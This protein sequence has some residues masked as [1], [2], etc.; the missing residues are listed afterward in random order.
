[1]ADSVE[2][3]IDAVRRADLDPA[4]VDVADA[5][6]FVQQTAWPSHVALSPEPSTDPAADAVP[7]DRVSPSPTSAPGDDA[8]GSPST[9][10][11]TAAPAVGSEHVAVVDEVEIRRPAP[12]RQP[13]SVPFRAPAAPALPA[14]LRMAR[15]L[16]P[17]KRRVVAGSDGDLDADATAHLAAQTDVL[18]PVFASRMERWLDI[19]VVIDDAPSMA[20]SAQTVQELV[21]I[22]SELG[23]FRDIR[24][25]RLN[26]DDHTA[27]LRLRA[28][29]TSAAAVHDPRELV[30]PTGRRAVV[31]V[32]DCLGKAWSDGRMAAALE[33]WADAGPVAVV[34][35]L[36]QRLWDDCGP[37]IH[38]V[39]LRAKTPG[40]A[41]SDLMVEINDDDL[42]ELD[43]ASIARKRLGTVVP[44]IELGE[45]WL[46]A[47]AAVVAGGAERSFRGKALFL[48]LM[49]LDTS[50]RPGTEVPG[51]APA[52]PVQVVERF[53]ATA[54]TDALSLAALLA[55]AAPLTLPVMRLVQRAKLPE[56]APT[57]LRE[58]FLGKLLEQVAELPGTTV[59]DHPDNVVYDFV[60]GVRR[61]L[62]SNLTRQEALSVLVDV[63]RYLVSR[64]GAN[65][66]FL[67][68]LAAE[69]P[70]EDLDER[71]RAFAA[72]AVEVLKSLGGS[73]REKAERLQKLLERDGSIESV[74]GAHVD[75]IE[76]DAGS[77]IENLRENRARGGAGEVGM[78][79]SS[80]QSV[81]YSTRESEGVPAGWKTVPPRN[82]NF[83]GRDD[84][85]DQL[86]SLLVNRSQTAVLL[87]R[88]LYGLGGVGKTQLATEYVHRQ[89]EDYNLVWWI[90]AE[91]PAEI[92]RSLVELS[93]ELEIAETTD[94]SETIRRVQQALAERQPFQHWLLVFDNVGEP[95]KMVGLVPESRGGHV[96]ITTRDRDWAEQGRAVEV[97]KFNRA[98]SVALL[99]ERGGI[100]ADEADEIADRLADLPIS[101]AQAAAWHNETGQRVS[102][103]LRR[104]NE[105]VERRS[106]DAESLGYSRHAAAAMG[107][108]FE[109]LRDGSPP[110]AQL[111]QLASY[112]GP[113]WISLEML[114]R[115]RM[116]TDLSRRL[117]RV[118]RDQSPL[119][120]AI[121]DIDRLELA[122]YDTRNDRFQI[123]RLVQRMVQADMAPEQQDAVRATVQLMLAHANPGN[124]DRIPENER[125][126]HAQLSAH[127]VASGVIQSDEDEARQVVLDQIRYRYRVGDFESSRDL[128]RAV[129]EVWERRWGPD[130]EMTLIARRHLANAIRELGNPT[131]ALIMDEEVLRRFQA[132]FGPD[133]EHSMATVN[134]VS[135]DL[136]A[137]G[138][139]VQAREL[140]E[141]NY[142]R[143]RRVLGEE[144]RSTLR[145]GGN[146]AVDL[147]M[148]GEYAQALLLDEEI[149]GTS[150]RVFGSEDPDSLLVASN[151]ARDL[152]ALGRFVDALRRQEEVL[153]THERVNGVNH[154][155]VLYARRNIVISYRKL[156][157]TREAI[158]EA[159]GLW[160]AHRN[161]L[162]DNHA[163]TLLVAQSLTNALRDSGNL[164][165]AI[166]R[167]EDTWERYRGSY[168]D[169]P[170][171]Q[172]CAVNLAIVYRQA[173]RIGEARQLNEASLVLLNESFGPDHPY[174][175]CCAT[176]LASDLGAAGD[177]D[178]AR[179]M[180]GETLARSRHIRG[181]Q[182]P[183]TLACANNHSIDLIETGDAA[184]GA[185][186]REQTIETLRRYPGLG[187]AHPD[188]TLA[189]DGKR[190]DCDIEP[191]NT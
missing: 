65:M 153:P 176:N 127:I 108:A 160:L 151:V 180:S 177:Y 76:F 60:A 61:E 9:G 167:G 26:S 178:A 117:G 1:M 70:V 114:H 175:L 41:N 32:A 21:A 2:R 99:Q 12:G 185:A 107:L 75:P 90:A 95:G 109:Q 150:R 59:A 152:N 166:E 158:D 27:R 6:W 183:Y 72:V 103:Y 126:K 101:L 171:T 188:T 11:A 121:K 125:R 173:G 134:S 83:V 163:A 181:D 147:R 40:A 88:A 186:L 42:D 129:V 189:K 4:P 64:M 146:L 164:V 8:E 81:F 162:G 55:A 165:D 118:L 10:D 148:V 71:G 85:L 179:R 30:D 80:A 43:D 20:V 105:E 47:W 139:F 182:H 67:A 149:L 96:L 130:D 62:I 115:G 34:Q 155:Q 25:W 78:T 116:A 136:R 168:A 120:R 93:R 191:P 137:V 46:A 22:L 122:R 69:R 31:V 56:S 39:T 132:V 142:R 124:P 133:H 74:D 172:V 174:S 82:P 143:Q 190:I 128:A 57:A 5:L 110:A 23:A 104:F 63:S 97:G 14:R 159:R 123:H 77:V 187:E 15:A 111:L 37:T 86:R 33:A 66:D 24:V 170:F 79:D 35:P 51:G 184:E 54:S 102:E 48:G 84:M 98:E 135:A 131:D 50:G 100:S 89:R 161:R 13:P 169:H 49:D 113:E 157:R 52:G 141:E 94:T 73:Y 58:I 7:P 106:G 19:A 138:R 36:A 45:R 154:P 119:Q 16:R 44:V 17:L 29:T 18:L 87:P 28:G 38:S 91:D 144:D 53:A 156:G 68:L 3:I 140:D 112:F 92:R 145:T